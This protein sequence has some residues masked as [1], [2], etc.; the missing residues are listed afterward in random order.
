[1]IFQEKEC[2]NN[3][4]TENFSRLN[5]KNLIDFCEEV[6]E[7][8]LFICTVKTLKIGVESP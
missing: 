4:N 1:M 2:S 3:R 6:K 5:R 8:E 7:A